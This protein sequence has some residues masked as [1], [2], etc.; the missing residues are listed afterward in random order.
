MVGRKGHQEAQGICVCSTISPES[1]P[2]SKSL[3][4]TSPAR[5]SVL[6]KMLLPCAVLDID[7]LLD[8]SWSPSKGEI[9]LGMTSFSSN[10]LCSVGTQLPGP[11]LSGIWLSRGTWTGWKEER[12]SA[13]PQDTPRAGDRNNRPGRESASAI[14]LAEPESSTNQPLNHSAIECP[15]STFPRLSQMGNE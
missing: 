5:T 6:S 4:R 7:T 15:L 2:P 10:S 9:L 13:W 8:T 3:V 12:H 1:S 11:A 14:A